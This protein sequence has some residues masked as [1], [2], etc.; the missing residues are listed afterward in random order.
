MSF[1]PILERELR[2]AS[3]RRSTTRVRWW[4]TLVALSLSVLLLLTFLVSPAM[5]GRGNPLFA[6]LTAYAF[7]LCLLFGVLLSADALA[8][9]K[10]EG[11]LGLLLLTGLKGFEIVLGKFLAH[12]LNAFYALLALLPAAALP[13]LLGGVSAAEYLR[14]SLALVNT[15]FLSLATGILVSSLSRES[16]HA[17][18]NGLGI[19][20]MLAAVL[21]AMAAGFRW[22]G[23]APAW[24]TVAWFSPSFA[25]VHATGGM[26]AGQLFWTSLGL[27]HALAWC[28]L[29]LAAL[30]L[31]A[32]SRDKPARSSPR[33]N[34]WK[35]RRR[36][37]RHYSAELLT[38]NP[39][40]W[41]R[42]RDLGIPWSAWVVV[43]LWAITALFVQLLAGKSE[44]VMLQVQAAAPFAFLL[45]LLFALETCR[46]YVEARR[47]GTLELLLCTPLSNR[48]V[49]YGQMKAL[50]RTYAAPLIAL[51]VI[52][53]APLLV[54]AG[55]DI[56]HPLRELLQSAVQAAFLPGVFVVRL[57][58]DL[59]A[60]LWLGTALA[61]T[62]NRPNTVSA[63][64][65]LL[66]LILPAP[67][68]VCWIDI[69]VDLVLIS[70]ATNKCRLD[71]RRLVAEQYQVFSPPN[72][73]AAAPW[74]S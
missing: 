41:L 13:F 21:P 52:L 2:T 49:I 27:S 3:R 37:A 59:L 23:L 24:Q 11:T 14:M 53:W 38:R 29:V 46:F 16:Q 7:I 25:Y 72:P 10:R 6:P 17:M 5:R 68:S 39:V 73:L 18:G 1:W 44:L 22:I 70:W 8:R 47:S 40:I 58:A 32:F 54:R 42:R 36:K 61:L 26:Y 31:P 15:L 69:L 4:T 63:W 19:V 74:R 35:P 28:F 9:E 57:A 43:C 62:S 55:A 20:I 56:F 51:L 64:T 50:V 33:M 65:V 67:L 45:K 30:S 71:L 12:S 34:Q 60:I 48:A 66:V